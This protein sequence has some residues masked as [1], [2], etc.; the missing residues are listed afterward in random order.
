VAQKMGLGPK[1]RLGYLILGLI[2]LTLIPLMAV[3]YRMGDMLAAQSVAMGQ[4]GL[5]VTVAVMMGQFMVFFVGVS[6]LMSTLYYAE[7]LET[8]QALPLTGR[9]IMISKVM[10]AYV[11]QLLLSS[12]LVLPF[13][14]PLGLRMSSPL[15]WL[16]ALVVDLTIPAIPLALALLFTVLI[17][18]VTSGF[19]RRDLFRVVFGVVFFVLIIG[20][21]S[22]NARMTSRGPE[23]VMEAIMQRNGL[24]QVV[25]GYYPPL[26]W[27]AWSMTGSTVAS[28]LG[29]LVLFAG[30]SMA[31][32]SGVAGGAQ[33]W[34]L[35]G[36]GRDVRTAAGTR[37][38]TRPGGA[39]AAVR[40]QHGL[41]SKVRTPASAVALR[42]HWVLTRTPNFLLV[43]LTNMAVIPIMWVFS[44][45]SG[46]EIR[47]LFGGLGGGVTGSLV[48]VLIAVQGGLAAM[49][50]VS[51]TAISR[52][53]GTFWL[54]KMIPV[55]ARD[56]MRGK[57]R[58]SLAVTMV[59]LLTLLVPAAIAFRLDAPSLAVLAVLGI[60]VSWPV[61]C[62]CI[63][64]D[65]LSPRLTW[66]DP[67]QAMKGN[68]ATLGAMLLSAVYLF[69][70]GAVVRAVFK[71]GLIGIPLY[72]L[73]AGMATASGYVFQ[74]YLENAAGHRY[75]DIEA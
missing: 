37:K 63:L 12:A 38:T 39:A 41:F 4:P 21:Q 49:N 15:F 65:L 46:G 42:D 1:S 61:T 59:Q 23:E 52:E 75:Q 11:A 44:A 66:T 7:D 30:I 60:L 47:A 6:A 5:P 14:L 74:R 70:G 32:L 72:L 33:G 24:I 62:I 58:Y 17:M 18:R 9:Q 57:V 40:D 54:S 50:Q 26:K 67:H 31:A 34:F 51:S 22:V 28:S 13:V 69:V 29:G 73:V 48:L 56:Q 53:G 43:T 16:S 68:L 27:A 2:F 20:L 25:S 35:G 10:V 19:K 64:N 8:L 3:L 71:A 36:T 45:I 55:P